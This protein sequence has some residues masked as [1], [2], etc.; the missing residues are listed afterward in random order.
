M[1]LAS[2]NNVNWQSVN[3]D[4]LWAHDNRAVGF[5]YNRD[6]TVH[7][8]TGRTHEKIILRNLDYYVDLVGD[9]D[10]GY[11]SSARKLTSVEDHEKAEWLRMLVAPIAVLGRVGNAFESLADAQ[12]RRNPATFVAF[13]INDEDLHNKLLRPCLESLLDKRIITGNERVADYAAEGETVNEFLGNR[14]V[15]TKYDL[16]RMQLMQQLH[17]MKPDQ[18]KAAMMKLGLGA[19]KENSWQHRAE[20]LGI[21]SPGQKFWA[22]TSESRE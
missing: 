2:I 14:A 12:L 22:P 4:T 9:I 18:K 11:G 7:S 20:D 16:E 19:K 21:V 8:E 6:G 3:P 15:G 17:L 5:I 10:V 1:K 13:W